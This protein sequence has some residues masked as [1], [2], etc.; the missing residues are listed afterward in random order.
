VAEE[1]GQRYRVEWVDVHTL[2]VQPCQGCLCC[3]P[4]QPCVLPED[5]AH[6]VA[7]LLRDSD[8]LVIGTPTYWSNMSGPLK[9]LFDRVVTALIEDNPRGMPTP[10]HRGQ[11]ALIVTACGAPPVIHRLAGITPGTVRALRTITGMAG[12]RLVGAVTHPGVPQ[13]PVVSP[14]V[15]QAVRRAA[16]RL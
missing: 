5:D 3:R 15:L 8:A 14:R 11:R 1:V 13:P 10:R 4:D 7:R 6:R 16:R 2:T 9:T 12:Y